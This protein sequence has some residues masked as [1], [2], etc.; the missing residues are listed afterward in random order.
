MKRKGFTLI[1]L[2]VVIGIIGI[3]AS[4]MV[5]VM[6]SGNESAL[7]AK[8][9]ANMKTLATA[10]QSYGMVDNRY[11]LAGSVECWVDS[12]RGE[13]P[14]WLSWNSQ[15]I[16]NQK[17]KNGKTGQKNHVSSSSWFQSAYNQDFESSEYCYTNGA[18]WRYVSG[19]RD[20]FICPVH[21]RDKKFH[22][23]PPKW[24]Y[25]MN[26]WFGWD[27]S[28]GGKTLSS[29][30]KDYG[31]QSKTD[32]RLLFAEMPF[33]GIG[34]DAKTSSSS[35]T[36][37]DCTL[38]YKGF[39]GDSAQGDEVIGFNHKV[40]KRDWYAHIVYADGHTEKLRWPK[41]GMGVEEMQELTFWLCK[42]IDFAFSDGKYK[43]VEN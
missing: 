41:D 16:Y 17:D 39:D 42:G 6:S 20:V 32:R 24:T 2:L 13:K 36:Q 10:V 11:P 12:R 38:Q 27:T 26:G 18:L 19:I 22:D 7:A 14:G 40:G 37:C 1:E 34:V 4:I 29:Y 8:C 9:M 25:V 15:G 43:K 33:S 23:R 21:A 5:T 28:K 3:L 30:W 35:G 31:V